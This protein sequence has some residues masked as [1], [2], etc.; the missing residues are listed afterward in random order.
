[1]VE[2]N[3]DEKVITTYDM[4]RDTLKIVRQGR[5]FSIISLILLIILFII[6]FGSIAV[7]KIL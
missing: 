6:A 3:E 1:M 7:L 5:F 4:A 2:Q